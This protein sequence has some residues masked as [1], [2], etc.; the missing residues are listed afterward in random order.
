MSRLNSYKGS[1]PLIAG[2]KPASAGYPLAEA[3]DIQIAE[4]GTRLDAK[5][6]EID[7]AFDRISHLENALGVKAPWR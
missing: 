1:I 5:L 4:D 2:L 6:L 7:S 3:N